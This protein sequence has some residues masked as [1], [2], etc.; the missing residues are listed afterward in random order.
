M[1]CAIDGIL[2]N[3]VEGK[4][5]WH[6]TQ[7]NEVKALY[8][9]SRTI[10]VHRVQREPALQLTEKSR[11]ESGMSVSRLLTSWPP[12]S[13]RPRN[14]IANS[15]VTA[16]GLSSTRREPYRTYSAGIPCTVFI[17]EDTHEHRR[18]EQYRDTFSRSGA[19]DARSANGRDQQRVPSEL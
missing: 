4:Y 5:Y 19:V 17:G 2:Q 8:P 9:L 14:D 12:Q 15:L 16:P 18:N 6:S 3:S 7:C 11:Y 1:N 10:S 13:L